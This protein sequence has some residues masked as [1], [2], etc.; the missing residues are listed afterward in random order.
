VAVSQAFAKEHRVQVGDVVGLP[1]PSGELRLRVAA[2]TTNTGWPSGALTLNQ[3]DYQRAWLTGDPSAIEVNLRAGVSPQQ[4][5]RSVRGAIGANAALS[6]QTRAQREA[7]FRANAQQALRTLGQISTLLLLVAALSIALAL[8]T[9]IWQ[10]RDRLASLKSQGFDAL[11]LW[12][13]V[14]LESTIVIAIGCVDGALLGVYGHA[15]EDRWLRLQTGFPAPFALDP[16]EIFGT[17][18]LLVGVALL[19]VTIPGIA[20]ARVSARASFQE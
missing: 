14:L 1:T 13:S 20:A 7:Q 2:L 11:Q 15:L 3:G 5:A 12:R 17:L 16:S 4:G 19:V 6:V 8:S 10:R 9:A 18:A